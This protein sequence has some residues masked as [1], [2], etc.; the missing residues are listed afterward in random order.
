MNP[1]PRVDLRTQ[2]FPFVTGKLV[3]ITA[4]GSLQIGI[5]YAT[6]Y[7]LY[8]LS[9]D[10]ARI[11]FRTARDLLIVVARSPLSRALDPQ[12][13][14]EDALWRTEA[15]SGRGV[16]QTRRAEGKQG[17][18]GASDVGSR[19]CDDFDSTEICSLS[20]GRIY[21]RQERHPSGPGLRRKE[22][23]LYGQHFWAR[24]YFVSTVGRD[25]VVIREYIKNQE[26]EDM[27]LD[28]MN[29]WR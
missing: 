1:N 15:A 5:V 10:P 12:I 22:T 20:G 13:T 18:G 24:G 16:P 7:S 25:E 11:G 14:P 4:Q 3:Y 17:R 19:P 27:R 2:I 8:D 6:A 9:F 26:K 28:Q 23:Q 29:L 21:Q